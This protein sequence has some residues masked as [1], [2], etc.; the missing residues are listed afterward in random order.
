M[1]RSVVSVAALALFA[2]EPSEPFPYDFSEAPVAV[3][4]E[5]VMFAKDMPCSEFERNSFD[6]YFRETGPAQPLVLYVHGGG[7]TG[8]NKEAL[9]SVGYRDQF[10]KD[11]VAGG[12]AIGTIGYR[13]LE[14]S[15]QVGVSKSLNDVKRCLQYVRHHA[16]WYNIDPDRI[17]LAGTSAGAGA[18][19]WLA[20]HD[21]MADP[22]S[23]DPIARE[24]TRVTTAAVWETQATYDLLRWESDVF[25]EYNLDLF[26]VAAQ[27]GLSELLWSFYGI[28][29]DDQLY[30]D[31]IVA[32]RED[33]DMLGL[34]SS[35]DPEFWVDNSGVP[36]GS[37]FLPIDNAVNALYHHPNHGRELVE[38]A[39]AVG[40]NSIAYL[41]GIDIEDDSGEGAT[42]FLLRKLEE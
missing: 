32:Y 26:S 39:D 33:V 27:F 38:A 40:V 10:L 14:D 15:D 22:D 30:D 5:S 11:I 21:D 28:S 29:A 2:C 8:G 9:Y 25:P 35:E 23:E 4:D 16:D 6:M 37:P 13:L 12:A 36:G 34:L 19:L 1:N 7:F 3:D 42:Q 17:A 41:P 18:A 24:S 20:F 31:D